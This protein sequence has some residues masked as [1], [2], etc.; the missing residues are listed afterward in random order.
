MAG[1]LNYGV[2]VTVGEVGSRELLASG[3]RVLAEIV[4]LPTDGHGLYFMA[5]VVF[6]RSAFESV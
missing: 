6:V 5:N 3:A 4:Q 2:Y 1:W